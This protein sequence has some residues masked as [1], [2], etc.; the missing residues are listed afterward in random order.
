MQ[1]LGKL[2]IKDQKTIAKILDTEH[3]G[4]FATIDSKG[5]PQ[6]VPMNFAYMDGMI[7]MHSHTKGE[8]LDNI[9][10]QQNAGFEVDCEYEYLPSYFEDEHDASVADTLYASIIIK[11]T[12][13]IIEDKETKCRALNALMSKYQPEGRYDPLT[14][15]NDVLDYVAVIC[16][17]P[18]S[19]KG[20]YKIGQHISESK[21][22]LLAKKIAERNSPSAQKTLRIMGYEPN[23]NEPKRVA[24]PAV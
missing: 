3:T 4:R 23:G 20:K 9:A 1:L 18:T 13:H 6:I 16:V 2:E 8:K 24:E 7:Y 12:A 14:P 11:G 22:D 10:R 17:R 5:F 19:M 15:A 21:R